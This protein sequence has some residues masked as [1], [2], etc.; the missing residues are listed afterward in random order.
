MG[1]RVVARIRPHQ[2]NESPKDIIVSAV[3]HIAS[4]QPTL[5]RIPNPKNEGEAFTFQFSS[6]YGHSATQQEIFDNE[7]LAR[8]IC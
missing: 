5:V 2:Q 4:D 6:V 7:G 3:S 1:I 8:F